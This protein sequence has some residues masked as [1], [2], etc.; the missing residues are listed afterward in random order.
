MERSV[1]FWY[2]NG[3]AA[4]AEQVRSIGATT[5]WVKA[6]GD[7]GVV[8]IPD[9]TPE[10]FENEQWADAYLEPLT[11]RG[12]VCN[13][14]FYNW[15]VEADKRAVIVALEHR[16]ADAIGLN[17]ETE[18]RVQS[19]HSPYTNL[20]R[21]NAYAVAWVEDL[22]NQIRARFCRVPQI[23][24][25][26]VPSWYD[27]PYEG[28][29]AVCDFAHPQHYWHDELMANGENQVEAHFRRAP[30][31]VC[32]P[33]LTACREYDDAGVLRLANSALLHPIQG[34]SAWEAGNAAFQANAM[35]QAYAL[36]PEGT[37][38]EGEVKEPAPGTWHTY[39]NARNEP[40]FVWNPG[41]QTRRIIA[42]NV[43]D[44]GMTVESFTEEGMVLDVSVQQNEQL[45]WGQPRPE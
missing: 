29:A 38:E 15:P 6:G 42:P 19:P 39:V 27:F 40:I 24:F 7:R 34:F 45:P 21:G 12:I 37:I 14:W 1:Y 25:S 43:A 26:G 41:G 5:A 31:S 20:M 10:G 33:V 44:L 22:R 4:K 32:I 3:S 16:W 9:P 23:G 28:F 2:Y 18:W 30:E 17:P 36:L 11:S 13:P 8:W 35:R